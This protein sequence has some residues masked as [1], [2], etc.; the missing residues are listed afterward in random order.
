MEI[1][2]KSAGS[3]FKAE[4]KENPRTFLPRIETFQGLKS[5][6]AVPALLFGLHPVI[7]VKQQSSSGGAS[8]VLRFVRAEIE[9]LTTAPP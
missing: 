4:G 6:I 1:K 9:A 7:G 3:K 8:Q 2:S 5:R